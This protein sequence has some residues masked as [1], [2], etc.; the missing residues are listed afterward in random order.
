M[1]H[2]GTALLSANQNRVNFSCVLLA[3][4]YKTSL[5]SQDKIFWTGADVEELYD[6][7]KGGW[8]YF[9]RLTILMSDS[10]FSI[11][12]CYNHGS[13]KLPSPRY[14]FHDRKVNRDKL[15][16]IN[17]LGKCERGER[18]TFTKTDQH[19]RFRPLWRSRWEN[20]AR[21]RNQADCRIC[22]I[23]A[24]SRVEK[25]NFINPIGSW[26]GPNFLIRTATAGGIHR[27]DLFLWTNLR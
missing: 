7:Y 18:L 6:H 19:D 14:H 26:S 24:R 4:K 27:V 10:N 5:H 25:K 9:P 12:W 21:S 11:G 3:I 17:H 20:S 2:F 22:R 8:P 1:V 23:S 15:V 13:K 16:L